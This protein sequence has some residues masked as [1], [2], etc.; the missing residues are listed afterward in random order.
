MN[1]LTRSD[2]DDPSKAV[3]ILLAPPRRVRALG[4]GLHQRKQPKTSR[5]VDDRRP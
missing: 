3:S 1:E 4:I 5:A 2:G